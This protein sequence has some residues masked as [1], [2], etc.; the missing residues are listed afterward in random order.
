MNRITEKQCWRDWY[1]K[2]L[3]PKDFYKI[4]N[5]GLCVKGSKKEII[6]C[7]GDRNIP[8]GECFTAPVKDS[9]NGVIQFNAETL[10]H[11]TV[12]S[13]IRLVFENGKI[14]EAT[15]SDTEKLNEILDSDEGD[16]YIGA[17]AIGFNP[18]IMKPM[19]DI[20]LDEKIAG[21]FHFTP[22]NEYTI[23]D[24]GNRSDVHW[25][26]VLIQRPDYGGG[27]IWFDDV[28]IRKDGEF[29]VPELKG[30][31]QENLV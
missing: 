27:E 3:A 13:D 8:D 7:A 19:K 26:M 22:G 31:N 5:R 14:I 29:V 30:L 2:K 6:A 18:Y 24:T 16:R 17:F 15:G 21:S 23:A 12:F 11:G 20:L 28:L 25:D 9:V 1:P 10:Y 4:E